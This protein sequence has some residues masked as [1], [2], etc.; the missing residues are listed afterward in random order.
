MMPQPNLV[1]QIAL[2]VAHQPI[3]SFDLELDEQTLFQEHLK[4]VNAGEAAC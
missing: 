3:R 2:A 1:L 4:R